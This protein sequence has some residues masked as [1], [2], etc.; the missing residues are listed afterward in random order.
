MRQI[1]EQPDPLPG[2]P[3]NSTHCCETPPLRSLHDGVHPL[4]NLHLVIG[5]RP[6]QARVECWVSCRIPQGPSIGENQRSERKA[7]SVDK[8]QFRD[9]LFEIDL[10]LELQ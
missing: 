8:L 4:E 3:A 2:L 6:Q 10:H 7:L 1:A 9:Q 5:L